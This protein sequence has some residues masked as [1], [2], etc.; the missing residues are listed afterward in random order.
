MSAYLKKRNTYP[1][2][3]SYWQNNRNRKIA[4]EFGVHESSVMRK[5][6]NLVHKCGTKYKC[7]VIGWYDWEKVSWEFSD[8]EIMRAWKGTKKPI[9]ATIKAWRKKMN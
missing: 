3:A 7:R 5:R 2:D 4:K 6:R 9:L 8:E 1:V